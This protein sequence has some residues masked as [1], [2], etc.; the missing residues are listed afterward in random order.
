MARIDVACRNTTA[1]ASTPAAADR[2]WRP[3]RSTPSERRPHLAFGVNSLDRLET[4]VPR[5]ERFGRPGMKII[6]VR[7]VAAADRNDVAKA[8]GGYDRR[9]YAFSLGDGVDDGG[10]AVN[11]EGHVAALRVRSRALG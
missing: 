9:A 5:H 2:A 3:R 7:A 11:E 8:L 10:A 4:Q 1:T 6:Q